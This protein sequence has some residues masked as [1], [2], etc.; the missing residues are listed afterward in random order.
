MKLKIDLSLDNAAFDGADLQYEAA[1]IL[2]AIADKVEN[3]SFSR[4]YSGESFPVHD[5]NG[6]KTGQYKYTGWRKAKK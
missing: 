2:R 3:L 1:R 4:E 5:L 6:Q